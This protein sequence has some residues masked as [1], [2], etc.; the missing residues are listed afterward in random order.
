MLIEVKLMEYIRNWPADWQAELKKYRQM[1]AKVLNIESTGKSSCQGTKK[2]FSEVKM[3]ASERYLQWK[4]SL[5]YCHSREL[6]YQ[7]RVWTVG[8]IAL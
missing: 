4:M 5:K 8:F 6:F 7:R 2:I 3:K 1:P